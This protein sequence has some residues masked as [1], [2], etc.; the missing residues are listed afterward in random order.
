MRLRVPLPDK[1]RHT[2]PAPGAASLPVLC[3]PEAQALGRPLVGVPPC[4]MKPDCANSEGQQAQ[5]T[6]LTL[7]QKTQA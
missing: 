5:G 1:R 3:P 4:P 7:T 2:G 6:R